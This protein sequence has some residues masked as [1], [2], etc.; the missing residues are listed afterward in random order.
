LI[1]NIAR[2]IISLISSYWKIKKKRE[3]T[4]PSLLLASFFNFSLGLLQST[5]TE[6]LNPSYGK[7]NHR[8]AY[9][10]ILGLNIS[11]LKMNF[12]PLWECGHFFYNSN[13][14]QNGEKSKAKRLKNH[15]I[16]IKMNN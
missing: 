11:V 14:A 6:V 7:T 5:A 3:P 15:L 16:K 9:R 12:N 13:L 8:L 1:N 4:R 10:A 2:K